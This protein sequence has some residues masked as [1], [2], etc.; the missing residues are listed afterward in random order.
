MA[1]QRRKSIKAKPTISAI[2]LL[3]VIISV[4]LGRNNEAF[5]KVNIT[6]DSNIT[7]STSD[8]VKVHFIDVGQGSSTLV[9]CGNTGILI[10]A[11]EREY[12][13][14]VV[15]YLKE[16]GIDRLEYVVASHPHSD[17][18]GGIKDV[19]DSVYVENII[20]PQLTEINIPTTRI[21]ENLLLAIDEKHIN[22]MSANFGDKYTVGGAE[23]EILGPVEQVKDLNNMSVI[24]KIK[25]NSVKFMVLADAEKQELNSIYRRNYDFRCNV[26][27]M[28]HHGSRTSIH[29]EFL[30]SVN[31]KVAI[32]SCGRDNSYGHPHEEA[33]EYLENNKIEY[34]RTDYVGNIVFTCNDKGY[35]INYG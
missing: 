3:I 33:L 10:D 18:I 15:G 16:A 5:E 14:T 13:K 19:L 25:A 9:Q 8:V 6:A 23:M 11:G 34:Y 32:I 27:A 2:A 22:V 31:A 24:C 30:Q 20:M 35:A 29:N 4:I 28:G 12:G 17:H 7:A 21:Y 1:N 26:I